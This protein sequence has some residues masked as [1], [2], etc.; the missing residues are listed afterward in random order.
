MFILIADLFDGVFRGIKK[1]P[2]IIGFALAGSLL[3]LT[4]LKAARDQEKETM[5]GEKVK[6]A[7]VDIYG[8]DM[9]GEYDYPLDLLLF[10]LSGS[11]PGHFAPCRL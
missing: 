9:I 4:C 3:M 5:I 11:A 10:L 7:D 6:A 2:W 1:R 8:C